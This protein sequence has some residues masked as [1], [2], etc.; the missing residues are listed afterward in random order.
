[1]P[2]V[3]VELRAVVEISNTRHRLLNEGNVGEFESF[4][5]DLKLRLKADNVVIDDIH[6]QISTVLRIVRG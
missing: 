4:A 6:E 3:V 2:K 1:M 5:E